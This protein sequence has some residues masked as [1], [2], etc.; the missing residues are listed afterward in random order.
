MF[1]AGVGAL[2]S[3]GN[4]HSN[5]GEQEANEGHGLVGNE[6]NNDGAYKSEVDEEERRALEEQLGID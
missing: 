5:D 3:P 1:D 4:V 2:Y 6:Q